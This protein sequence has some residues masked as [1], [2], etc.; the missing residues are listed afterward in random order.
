[1]SYLFYF[2]LQINLGDIDAIFK[3]R[4]YFGGDYTGSPWF[5]QSVRLYFPFVTVCKKGYGCK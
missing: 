1:M 4:L 2:C 3:V 5:L